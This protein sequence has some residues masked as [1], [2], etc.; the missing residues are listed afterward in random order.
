MQTTQSVDAVLHYMCKQP[1]LV[2][3]DQSQDSSGVQFNVIP[4]IASDENVF[5]KPS[6]VQ[7]KAPRK[8]KPLNRAQRKK[9]VLSTKERNLKLLQKQQTNTSKAMEKLQIDIAYDKK[10]YEILKI[11]C[12]E[13][14]E[15]KKIRERAAKKRKRDAERKAKAKNSSKAPKKRT[16]TLPKKQ[17]SKSNVLVNAAV[18]VANEMRKQYNTR[19]KVPN[20]INTK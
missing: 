4:M 17:Q 7:V 3:K 14:A 19:S 10:D 8:R 2:I 13:A 16:K 11:V 1:E 9:R 15:K 6:K 18:Q 20:I 5:E 12:D